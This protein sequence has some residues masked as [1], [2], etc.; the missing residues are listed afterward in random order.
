MKAK[1]IT[2]FFLAFLCVG[3]LW[4]I[5]VDLYKIEQSLPA[6]MQASASAPTAILREGLESALLRM[7]GSEKLLE[8]S[9][10]IK[11][12]SEPDRY[13][14]RFSYHQGPQ[15][16]R[17]IRI[18]FNENRLKQLF[19][20]AQQGIWASNRPLILGWLVLERDQKTHW[21]NADSEAAVAQTLEKAFKRRAIPFVFP[22]LDLSDSA[23]VSEQDLIQENTDP[24]ENAAKRYAPDA[25]LLGRLSHTA[26]AWQGHWTLI[27]GAKKT[28]WD[29]HAPDL[30]TLLQQS[31]EALK[32]KLM[33]QAIPV[34]LSSGAIED[35]IGSAQPTLV[36]VSGISNAAD[37]AQVLEY[38]RRLPSVSAVEV[39][40]IMPEKTIF[41][42]ETT[43]SKETL[44]QSI[45]EGKVFILK[46][47]TEG[48]PHESSIAL[49]YSA[50]R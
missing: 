5:T 38:L 45:E 6:Q 27:G 14:D 36:T 7:G 46:S 4:A 29:Q 43:V 48:V 37:Y 1:Q 20:N 18:L 31:A 12:L 33:E 24:L 21:V 17:F 32:V 28:T 42:I 23:Q 16:G 9:L 3:S 39:T 34:S 26:G 2:V 25:V 49:E 22:L 41:S 13:V 35:A 47:S 19:Q 11:A 10:I 30:D 50:A 44:L 8:N 40:Q 15:G